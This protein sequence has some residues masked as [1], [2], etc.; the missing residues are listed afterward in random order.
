M[1]KNII[2]WISR[3]DWFNYNIDAQNFL[4]QLLPV[5]ILYFIVFITYVISIVVLYR[6]KLINNVFIAHNLKPTPEENY[7][8]KDKIHYHN[9]DLIDKFFDIKH[10]NIIK[11][12]G[13]KWAG[14]KYLFIP[15][16]KLNTVNRINRKQIAIK[17]SGHSTNTFIYPSKAKLND[18]KK[19]RLRKNRLINLNGTFIMGHVLTK[20]LHLTAMIITGP[21]KDEDGVIIDYMFDNGNTTRVLVDNDIF[22]SD[23]EVLFNVYFINNCEMFELK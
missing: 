9:Q 6:N 2:E 22:L 18:W 1:F 12:I 20:T 7:N 14:R 8:E 15:N 4:K 21:T 5:F 17:Y 19:K 3:I 11:Q 10:T 16:D 13:D 23:I